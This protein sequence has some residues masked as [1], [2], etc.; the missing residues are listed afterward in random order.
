MANPLFGNQ[1]IPT[2]GNPMGAMGGMPN[3][4][5]QALQQIMGMINRGA[6]FK[7]IIQ[8]AKRKGISPEVV[9]E[10][11]CTI[12]PQFKQLRDERNKM[13]QSGKTQQDMFNDFAKQ[14][15]VDPNELN[16]TYNN[17]MKLVK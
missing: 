4:N 15:N 8:T 3:I 12:N 6:D 1:G 5:P 11:L 9:E 17:F 13:Q 7:T 2:N 10:A 16:K 14:A